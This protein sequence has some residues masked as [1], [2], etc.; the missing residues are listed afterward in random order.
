MRIRTI[1]L[2]ACLLGWWWSP[3]AAESPADSLPATGWVTLETNLAAGNSSLFSVPLDLGPLD[4]GEYLAKA[5]LSLKGIHGWDARTQSFVALATL[6]PGQG[7][8]LAHGPGKIAFS[9]QLVTA[10][11]VEIALDKGWNLIGVPYQSGVP[12]SALRITVDGK[13]E[14][15]A[16]AAEMKW[17][18]AVHT[19]REGKTTALAVETAVLEPWHGYWLYA[20]QPCQLS[21]PSPEALTKAKETKGKRSNKR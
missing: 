12:L 15:Y 3:V 20:Y 2:V 7:F 6:R 4:L 19:L 5:G 9:G 14:S 21:I 11:A 18:G 13:S 10:A 1:L 16:A 17:T 8:L